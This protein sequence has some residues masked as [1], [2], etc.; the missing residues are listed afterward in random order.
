LYVC[1]TTAHTHNNNRYARCQY[2]RFL[3]LSLCI[4]RQQNHQLL[5][6]A[7]MNEWT[8]KLLSVFPDRNRGADLDRFMTEVCDIYAA[9]LNHVPHVV[10]LGK[11]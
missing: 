3:D 5:A 7:K 10:C 9:S 8:E 11:Q 2:S 4:L 6:Q 1:S